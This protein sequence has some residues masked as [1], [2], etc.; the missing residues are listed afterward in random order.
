MHKNLHRLQRGLSL[1]EVFVALLVL[2]VGL[3]A[4]ARLQVDLV[5]GSADARARTVALS[6]A[7]EKIEDLRS[8]ALTDGA[9]AWS[10]SNAVNPAF[11]M[12]WSYIANN[13]GGRLVPQTT[14]NSTLEV[15]G[16]RFQRTWNVTDRN[17][18]N[19]ASGI[20]SR[21]KDVTVTV[22]WLNEAGATQSVTEVANVVEVPPGNVALAS[23]PVAVR[24]AGPQVSYTPG[25]APDVISTDIGGGKK[26]E[27]TKPLP[28]VVGNSGTN[29]V[30]FDVV[31]YNSN[32]KV[33][34]R[35]EFVSVNCSC[36]IAAAGPARTPAH[37]TYV[38]NLLREVPGQLVTKT[39]GSYN[40]TGQNFDDVCIV[41]CRDHHDYTDTSN[42]TN[43]FYNPSDPSPH[44]H[45]KREN[46]GTYTEALDTSIGAP[47]D[48]ACRLKRVNG[49]FQVFEDWNLQAVTAIPQND[50]LD[51]ASTQ[52]AYRNYVAALVR[53]YVDSSQAAP[54]V[55]TFSTTTIAPGGA[56][57]LQGRAIYID[58]MTSAQKASA[59]ARITVSDNQSV[60]EAVPWYEVNLT[61]IAN[62]KLQ[63]PD[64]NTDDTAAVN[65]Q[66]CSASV[67]QATLSGTVACVASQEI[68]D[69]TQ[70]T[71]NQYFRGL[72]KAGPVT[73]SR[74]AQVYLRN[75]N[76]GVTGT[77]AVTA[78]S[79][80][81][82]PSF[83]E[84]RVTNSTVVG[85]Q[86]SGGI[87]KGPTIGNGANP[88]PS[89]SCT[90]RINGG[91]IVP[92]PLNPPD[93]PAS[94]KGDPRSITSF[95]TPAGSSV[96]VT[97]NYAGGVV[98]PAQSVTKTAPA[99]DFNFVLQVAGTV[100][101]P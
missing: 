89:V 30:R 46:N 40:A 45:Y 32:N 91:A 59:A 33:T 38:G 49:V 66:T 1:V 43:Y 9:G 19:V 20:T 25:L 61:K 7:E 36:N 85:P 97:V 86:S 100:C 82:P 54:T 42:G 80:A 11:V 17:F 39:R 58:H 72:V 50:L 6:L 67:A 27:T 41:C 75:G 31:N 98:C 37:W 71:P 5:R 69:E 35:E 16:V 83:S 15:A 47:Y 55:P 21:T 84:Y 94:K 14:Y 34:R 68:I 29:V 48:E 2:S 93:S 101:S 90:Y 92:C 95:D 73:G 79:D 13:A 18:T 96:T 53:K 70:L 76:T 24:P 22:S 81:A 87:T 60:L 63:L 77:N 44:R 8:F 78:A 4:L 23:Q 99:S 26:R 51:G 88:W 65:G 52:T 57:Q 10:T 3:I 62:W 64:T 12:A 28:D 74:D 56:T